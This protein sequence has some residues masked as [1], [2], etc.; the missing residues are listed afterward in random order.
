MIL[1]LDTAVDNSGS[2]RCVGAVFHSVND[3]TP[4]TVYDTHLLPHES[5]PGAGSQ[6]LMVDA[7]VKLFKVF[8]LKPDTIIVNGLMHKADRCDDFGMNLYNSLKDHY[9]E[10]HKSVRMMG[11]QKERLSGQSKP[12]AATNKVYRNSIEPLIVTTSTYDVGISSAVTLIK[13]MHGDSRTPSI[14]QHI[15]RC[16]NRT[17]H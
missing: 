4:E 17:T 8:S 10:T 1:A 3:M 11:V 2:L 15:D 7:A 5:K 14:L 13:D 12:F 6:E 16:L 9:G